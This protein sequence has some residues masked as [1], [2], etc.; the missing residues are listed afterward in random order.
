LG[1]E[2]AERIGLGEGGGDEAVAANG[3]VRVKDK[4]A[5]GQVCIERVPII[6]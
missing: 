5:I 1:V 2:E 6:S 3:K 4:F